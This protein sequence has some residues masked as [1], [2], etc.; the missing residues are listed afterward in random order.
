ML[1]RALRV[2]VSRHTHILMQEYKAKERVRYCI[3]LINFV[4]HARHNY[5]NEIV[6]TGLS[7]SI[8]FLFLQSFL[9]FYFV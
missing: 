4:A 2:Y 6:I 9:L 8:I 3:N 1:I 5:R 7:S